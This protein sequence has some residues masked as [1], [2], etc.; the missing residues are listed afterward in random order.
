MACPY[1][2]HGARIH[3]D[4]SQAACG[5]PPPRA[6]PTASLAQMQSIPA[7]VHASL[8][9][10]CSAPRLD[11]ALRAERQRLHDVRQHRTS[12]WDN[13]ERRECL[14]YHLHYLCA[15]P[16]CLHS[17]ACPPLSQPQ[18]HRMPLASVWLGRLGASQHAPNNLQSPV[19]CTWHITDG[20][21]GPNRSAAG[22]CYACHLVQGNPHSRS[23]QSLATAHIM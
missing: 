17:G 9:N 13:T 15:H 18:A 7:G 4:P 14:I 23:S 12:D 5:I 2:G 8:A 16:V 20:L 1:G 6:C 19:A 10:F 3:R 11:N 22:A 21:E